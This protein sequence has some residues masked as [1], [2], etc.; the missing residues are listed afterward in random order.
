[1][2]IAYLITYDKYITEYKMLH[3]MCDNKREDVGL[4]LSAGDERNGK[5]RLYQHRVRNLQSD[6]FFKHK[7]PPL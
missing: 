3:I 4:L 2:I 5:Q 6:T 7:V 1:M